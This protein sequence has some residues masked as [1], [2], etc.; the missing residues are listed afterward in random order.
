[1]NWYTI[2]SVVIIPLVVWGLRAI[3]LPTKWCP[4]VAFAVA[5]GLVAIGKAI[6]VDLDVNTIQQAI[7][8]A[9]ATAGVSVLG[10]DT[11]KGLIT[12]PAK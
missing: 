1:M 9:L 12:P 4:V 2:L 5:V 7:I 3:K 6:G 8:T 10:Y 11:V